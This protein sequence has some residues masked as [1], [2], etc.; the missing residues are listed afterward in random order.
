MQDLESLKYPIGE[1][2]PPETISESMLKEWI[3]QLE[4][5]P[6]E[7]VEITAGLSDADLEIPYRPDGWT[8]RQVVHHLADSHINAYTRVH[9]TL[10]EEN[11][12]VRPYHE[13]RWAELADGKT[14][15][16]QLSIDILK[17]IH[18]RLVSL[19]KTLAISDFDRTYFHPGAGKEF[20]LGY[21]VGN[22]AWHG[23]HHLA[24][25]QLTLNV[26]YS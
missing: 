3:E 16:I 25:I 1:Y 6:H 11:P 5:L 26:N 24:H 7:I 19:L 15:D 17:A 9:L 20:T 18:K 23:K 10:T 2:N 4:T 8:V 12:T 14:G 21:L 13:E 22:Y